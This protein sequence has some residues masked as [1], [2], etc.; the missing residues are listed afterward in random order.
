MGDNLS[1]FVSTVPSSRRI[2]PRVAP[3]IF[4]GRKIPPAT[5][6]A[7]FFSLTGTKVPRTPVERRHKWVVDPRQE[8]KNEG[9]LGCNRKV[10]TPAGRNAAIIQTRRHHQEEGLKFDQLFLQSFH[11]AIE[12]IGSLQSSPNSFRH[13]THPKPWQEDSASLTDRSRG[14]ARYAA[15]EIAVSFCVESFLTPPPRTRCILSLV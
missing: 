6:D 2:R 9:C 8:Y 15:V 3:P 7:D 1:F 12:N 13:R 5:L 10:L 14:S 4:P 11:M